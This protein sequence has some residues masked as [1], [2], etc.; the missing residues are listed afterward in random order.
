MRET[1][2]LRNTLNLME[3]AARRQFLR[4]ALLEKQ[5][6]EFESVDTYL[7]DL[8]GQELRPVKGDEVH[9][10]ISCAG[11][12]PIPEDHVSIDS[13]G[14]AY[15]ELHANWYRIPLA[16]TSGK[17]IYSGT[18]STGGRMFLQRPYNSCEPLFS[19]LKNQYCSVEIQIY[20]SL[21]KIQFDILDQEEYEHIPTGDPRDGPLC[22]MYERLYEG[23]SCADL[24]E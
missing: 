21:T 20:R 16:G 13:C 1:L 14:D 12:I 10:R 2:W 9:W 3:Q 24:M 17:K 8:N 15:G 6:S 11:A 7:H 19:E 18:R 4:V 5:F 22:Q 23:A